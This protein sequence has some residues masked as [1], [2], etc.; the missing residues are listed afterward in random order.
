MSQRDLSAELRA[1]RVSAPAEV[2]E[3]VRLIAAS[4][5]TTREPRFTWRRALVVAVPVVAA[6]AATVVFARPSDHQTAAPAATTLVERA[7]VG[8]AATQKSLGHVAAA[9]SNPA[10]VG[11]PAAALP[12]PPSRTRVQRYGAYIALRV[13]TPDGVSTGV[14]RALEITSSLGGHPTSVHASSRSRSASADLVLRIP[15]ANV[16]RAT[17][18]LSQLG[19]ITAEQVDVQDL[20]AGLDTTTRTIARLQKELGGL[21]AETQT[22]AVA[23]QIAALTARVVQL[24]RAQ[25]TTIRTAHFATVRLHLA[26]PPLKAAV[27]HT[28]HGPFTWLV[29]A[30]LWL[31]IGTI[32]VLVLGIPVALIGLLIALIV[33]A[34][35]R[36][37]EDALLSGT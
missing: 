31:G 5:R 17:T 12:V 36:R 6:V 33:R 22:P 32:Y 2:R 29:R 20:Q 30:L 18:R 24:Q 4:D 27:H 1:A 26:T 16:Q 23:R 7:A 21:R 25:A 35:R 34:L 15:R 37:R 28:H 10:A 3:H 14:K 8:R 19:T 13:P 11:T 9:Q